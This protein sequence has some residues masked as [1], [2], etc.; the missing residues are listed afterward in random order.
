M[1]IGDNDFLKKCKSHRIL[2]YHVYVLRFEGVRF[3]MQIAV[4]GCSGSQ[5]ALNHPPY[6]PLSTPLCPPGEACLTV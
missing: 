3:L 4:I 1:D 6:Y 5:S 2:M